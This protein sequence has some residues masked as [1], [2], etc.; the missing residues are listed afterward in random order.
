[1]TSSIPPVAVLISHHVAD[2]DAWKKAFD[3]HKPMREEVS[4]LGHEVLRDADDDDL[5]FVY[6]PATDVKKIR[7]FVDSPELKTTMK[8]AGVQG[9]PVITLMKPKSDDSINETLP[10]LVARHEVKDY[11]AWRRIYDQFEKTRV[12][13]GIIG[14]AVNQVLG[15]PKQVVVYHQARDLNTLR[16]FGDSAELKQA[17]ERGGVVG[18]PDIHFVRSVEITQY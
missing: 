18:A 12:Q 6:C 9:P 8:K 3:A 10:G 16:A 5:V 13:Q 11:R 4:C 14:H 2:F 17:M 7:V 15:N 1:M